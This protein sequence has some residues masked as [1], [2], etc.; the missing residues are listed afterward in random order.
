MKIMP[1]AN[2]TACG[3]TGEVEYVDLVPTPFGPGM[4]SMRSVEFCECVL[5]QAPDDIDIDDIELVVA[6]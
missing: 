4:C 6:K 5:D 2:C 3:G 1:R